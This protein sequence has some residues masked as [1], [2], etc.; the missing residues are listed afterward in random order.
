ME[1]QKNL[2]GKSLEEELYPVGLVF[3]GV[4]AVASPLVRMILEKRD[5]SQRGCLFQV[6]FGMYCPGCGGTRAVDALL[7]GYVLRSVWYH[8]LVPYGA[9]LYLAFMISWTAAK[10]HLFGIR[11]GIRFRN[12]YLYGMLVVVAVNFVVKNVLKLCFGVVMI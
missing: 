3:L 4:A 8:P 12:G 5:L 2:E 6:L 9:G 11:R 10:W 1:T 7:H